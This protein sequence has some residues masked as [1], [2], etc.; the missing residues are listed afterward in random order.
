MIVNN[1]ARNGIRTF[2]YIVSGHVSEDSTKKNLHSQSEDRIPA[3]TEI[4]S[5]AHRP[6]I[7][8]S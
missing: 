2:R 8:T 7:A 3:T 6:L 5:Y 1:M 4:F